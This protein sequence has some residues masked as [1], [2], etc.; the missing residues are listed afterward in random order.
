MVGGAPADAERAARPLGGGAAPGGD[1]AV[2]P[3]HPVP[4]LAV[5]VAVD[6]GLDLDPA[7]VGLGLDLPVRAPRAGAAPG[8]VVPA[9]RGVGDADP[10]DGDGEGD[11]QCDGGAGGCLHL[12]LLVV[13]RVSGT[14]PASW[15]ATLTPGHVL[16][17]SPR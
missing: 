14:A 11:Q 17:V 1:V 4:G 9:A 7:V 15:G 12:G 6:L 5:V 13:V 8:H 2:V 3:Q 16:D 10:R